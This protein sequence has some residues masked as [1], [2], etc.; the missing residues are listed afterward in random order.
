[1]RIAAIA[2][3]AALPLAAGPT[4]ADFVDP[5]V[6]ARALSMGGAFV[7]V[8]GDPACLFWNPAAILGEERFQ[9]SGM[10]SLVYDAVD[11]LTQDYVG[12]TFQ[13]RPRVAVGAGWW[14]TGLADLYHEDL[15]TAAVAWEVLPGRAAIGGAALFFGMAAPGYEE[16]NDP[17]YE[18][19]Q[20][21]TSFSLGATVRVIE[22]LDAGVSL[23]NLL[24]PEIRLLSTTGDATKIGGRR[25]FGAS[26]LLQG[27]VRLSG[28]VRH[29]DVPAYVEGSWTAH[30]G[31]ESWFNRIVAIRAGIDDGNLA[32]GAGLQVKSV[33]TDV[34]LVSH[35]RL[36]NTYRATITLGF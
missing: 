19:A 13:V 21:E 11:G 34:G 35:E 29:H 22:N 32:A 26:Y 15:L 4:R 24:Q 1:L 31:A 12:A 17:A 16:L 28:E 30:V 2:M 25:R 20:W 9:I 5:Q 7:A 36:G 33:R 14:R 8:Q 18:G 3:A 6:G 10:R 23:E 27:I